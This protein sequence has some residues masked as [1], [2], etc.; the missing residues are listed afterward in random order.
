MALGSAG[1]V[2]GTLSLFDKLD[3]AIICGPRTT[4]VDV[5]MLAEDQKKRVTAQLLKWE[6]RVSQDG[7][8]IEINDMMHSECGNRRITYDAFGR[9]TVVDE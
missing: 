5:T 7:G 6:T 8:I 4:R 2:A 9:M 1:T 3:R